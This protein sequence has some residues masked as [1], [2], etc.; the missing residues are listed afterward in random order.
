MLLRNI[1]VASL[2]VCVSSPFVSAWTFSDATLA[3]NERSGTL[4]TRPF[5][6][7]VPL[8]EIISLPSSALARLRFTVRSDLTPDTN[9]KPHQAYAIIEDP[10][11]SL[12]SSFPVDVRENGR[13]RVDIDYKTIPTAL[14]GP[15]K[16][17]TVTIVLASFGAESPLKVEI[18]QVQP[19][20]NGPAPAGPIRFGPKPEIIHIFRPDSKF[21]SSTVSLFF[22][23]IV[24]FVAI[25]LISSWSYLGVM[26]SKLLTALASSPLGHLGF[27]TSIVAIEIAFFN[28]YVGST[29]FNLIAQVSV[30]APIA[31]L[32]GSRA[33]REVRSRRLKGEW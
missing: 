28:Y 29:I 20:Y 18:G 17:L 26:P 14:L 27:F 25:V 16:P 1:L 10:V 23:A 15:N 33:L 5:S 21:V 7:S 4:E 11:T 9:N 32:S 30:L 6:M 12:E 22:S 8:P 19:V 31:F 3:I 2:V 24:V 13:A